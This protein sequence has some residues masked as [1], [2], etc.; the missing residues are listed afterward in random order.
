MSGDLIGGTEGHAAV[1]L[2]DNAVS[3]TD[4]ADIE[5]WEGTM[6]AEIVSRLF[7]GSTAPKKTITGIPLAGSMSGAVA[8]GRDAGKTRLVLQAKAGGRVALELKSDDGYIFRLPKA[9]ISEL[10]LGHDTGEGTAFSCNFENDG[11]Y[12][13]LEDTAP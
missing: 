12:E 1:K 8:K 2:T 10:T 5:S 3:H 11:D 6:T 9:I 4:V 13:V 7:F